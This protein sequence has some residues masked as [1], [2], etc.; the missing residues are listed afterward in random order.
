MKEIKRAISWISLPRKK[1]MLLHCILS[2]PTKNQDANLGMIKDLQ[3]NFPK[4]KIGY[5]DH[6][7]P[8]NMN[9]TNLAF[10]LYCWR[11]E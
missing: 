7:K 8:G 2:Y 10:N 11:G 1:I 3:Y 5:S 9:V 6:T 4:I